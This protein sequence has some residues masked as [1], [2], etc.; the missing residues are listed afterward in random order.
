MTTLPET[1]LTPEELAKRWKMSAGTLK[2]W[3][4]AK[5]GPPFVPLGPTGRGRR[6]RVLYR[7]ADVEAWETK[8]RRAA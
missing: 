3:R 8:N 1:M 6:P 5:K 2:N 4:A 7:L